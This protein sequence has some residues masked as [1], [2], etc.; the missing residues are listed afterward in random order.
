VTVGTAPTSCWNTDLYSDALRA[1]RGPLYLRRS[2]GWLLPLEVERWCARPD[3]A[4]RSVL[5]RCRGSVLDIGCG[6]GRMVV[7]LSRRGSRTLGIDTSAA[8]IAHTRRGGGSARLASVFDPLPDEG[9]WHTG[10]LLDGN[11][12]I[13][14]DPAALL[15][16]L[17]EVI[18]PGG[19]LVAEAAPVEVDECVRARLYNGRA[20]QGPS[21]LW[22]RTGRTALHTHAA[23]AGWDT[24][25]QWTASGRPFLLLRRRS[26]AVPAAISSVATS[27]PAV[28][29]AQLRG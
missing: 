4:D 29:S 22:A 18:A 10:L 23:R 3:A 12:G 11:I 9:R 1:G 17:W 25:A 8:A 2:D 26:S 27:T 5:R 19:L 6:P 24:A 16:R 15:G 28:S 21:F 14:G 7:E 13:G 20:A